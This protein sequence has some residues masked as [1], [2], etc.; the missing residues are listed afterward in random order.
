[1]RLQLTD[2]ITLR[3]RA[4]AALKVFRGRAD[5]LVSAYDQFYR[6]GGARANE[7]KSSPFYWPSFRT[8]VPAWQMTDYA[9]YVNDGF[10]RNSLIYSAIMYKARSMTSAPL[11]AYTGEMEHPEILPPDSPLSKLVDRPNTHQSMLEMMSQNVVYIN[12]SGNCFQY[13]DRK[14]K[15]ALP[16][17][18]YSL[19]PDRVF[20]VPGRENGQSM[21]RGFLYVPEGRSAFESWGQ[22][23]RDNA[24]DEGR[25]FPIL[26]GDMMHTKFPNPGDPLEGMGYG[27]S[28]ISPGSHSADLDNS[29]TDYLNLFLKH[30]GVPAL[31][32]SFADAISD[33]TMAY[34]RERLSEEYGGYVNWI[35]PIVLDKGGT[36]SK[37]GL[38]F[39][40]LGSEKLDMRNEARILMALGVPAILVNAEVGLA[41]ATLANAEELRRQFWQ[42]TMVPE[43]RLFE[44]DYKYYL[45]DDS[46]RSWPEFDFSQVPALQQD[47]PVLVEAAHKLWQMS[48][49]ANIATAAVG[50]DIE[51][52]VG[53]DISYVPM[54]VIEAGTERPAPIAFGGGNSTNTGGDDE[55]GAADSTAEPRKMI[56]AADAKKKGRRES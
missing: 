16:E 43:A 22:V 15:N 27:L 4:A 53:G 38:T 32:F 33:P 7:Q 37:V 44:V 41:H 50:L 46:G 10:N 31:A 36:V 6:N 35:K 13:L 56:G 23:E 30:G 34:L 21:L 5:D 12:I 1:M 55:E 52:I 24:F 18:I 2:K 26:P 54:S 51:K 17:A 39:D 9:A 20:I 14:S 11:Q 40:E 49:P 48:Y 28:P 8:D 29:V 3:Q 42:D 47:V 19:R 45:R 25:V